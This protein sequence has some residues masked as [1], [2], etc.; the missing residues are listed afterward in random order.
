[1]PRPK[2]KQEL[3]EVI[4][5]ERMKLNKALEDLT[6]EQKLQPGACG[7]WSVKDILAH[8]VEWKQRGLRWYL[9]GLQGEVPKTP[10]EA[11]N[12]RELPALNH[13]IFETYKDW[14]LEDVEQAYEASYAETMQVLDE[15][16]EEEL[17]TPN[18]YEWTGNNL[19]RDYVNA[20]TAS[21]YRWASKLIRG[22][23]KRIHQDAA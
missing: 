15:M 21:H 19:L 22:F 3:N 8:L 7:D 6:N 23:S 10:D 11:Y 14:S 20:N 1:M 9:A 12:W 16:T 2:N 18:Q 5:K 17:F 4:Q 13:A